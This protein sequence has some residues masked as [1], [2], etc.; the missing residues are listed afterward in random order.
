[1]LV[2]HNGRKIDLS[3]SELF[4]TRNFALVYKENTTIDKAKRVGLTLLGHLVNLIFLYIPALIADTS[5]EIK[6]IKRNLDSIYPSIESGDGNRVST[7]P[8]HPVSEAYGWCR[9]IKESFD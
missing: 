1:M 2:E 8:E 4:F 6:Y 7:R 9:H 5:I 3:C